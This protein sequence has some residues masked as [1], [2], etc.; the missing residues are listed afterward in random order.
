VQVIA[1]FSS[2]DQAGAQKLADGFGE[3]DWL[4]DVGEMR[5]RVQQQLL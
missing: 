3:G 4:L 2:A 5:R 1:G